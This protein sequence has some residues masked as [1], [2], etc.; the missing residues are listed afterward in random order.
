MKPDRSP[1]RGCR[2]QTEIVCSHFR[3]TSGTIQGLLFRALV[4]LRVH[5]LQASA[6]EMWRIPSCR[7]EQASSAGVQGLLSGRKV[8]KLYDL[9]VHPIRFGA[10]IRAKM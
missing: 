10:K 2:K 3:D 6:G 4:S 7:S 5:G 9:K 1:R 8:I